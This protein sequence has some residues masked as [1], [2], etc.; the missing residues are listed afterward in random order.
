[1]PEVND[2]LD[3]F[4]DRACG[5]LESVP[6]EDREANPGAFE[7]LHEV[8]AYAK[9]VV[10]QTD[11]DLV[12]SAAVNSLESAAAA[13]A[14][15]PS[16]A[17]ANPRVYADPILTQLPA[18]PVSRGRGVEQSAKKAAASFQ[19]AATQRLHAVISDLS[20][21]E[22]DLAERKAA[23]D[24]QLGALR[25]QLDSVSSEIS[26]SVETV[27]AGFK[28]QVETLTIS[29]AAQQQALDQMLTRHS[30]TFSETQEQRATEFKA[31]IEQAKKDL[32]ALHSKASAEVERHVGEIRRM[33]KESSDLVGAIGLA[34]TAER[35]GEEAKEQK[36]VAD[37]LRWLTL[38]LA[39]GAIAMAVYAAVHNTGELTAV[40]SKL[41]VSLVF[42]G[43][44]T[45]TAR[46]S[47]RHRKRE[48]RARNLQ[49]ELT[50]FAPFIEPLDPVLKQAERVV[51][52]RKTFGHISSLPEAEEAEIVG[53]AASV[54]EFIKAKLAPG[55][56]SPAS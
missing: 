27:S 37:V 30:E 15:H 26:G 16:D 12:A 56:D 44:A 54:L 29:I 5:E 8:I 32:G 53:T 10:D 21:F 1:M 14:E 35:Y 42:G 51:M 45:Y 47:G 34:G 49:L 31:E 28:T 2:Q 48:E 25:E 19:R 55:D 6:E 50:A 41:A 20:A 33:E 24:E 38:V 39:V 4:L 23:I 43:L 40:G 46:Q 17:I 7:F 36:K 18:F 11:T 22:K 52:T 3:A 13:I 9:L